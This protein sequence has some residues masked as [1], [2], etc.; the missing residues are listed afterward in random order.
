ML[1]GM[2]LR[3]H[4]AD[5]T[6]TGSC[7]LV[8][9]NGLRLMLD[10]GMFQGARE[11]SR[12]ANSILPDDL[13]NVDAVILSHGHLDHCGRLPL[14]CRAGFRGVIYATPATIDVARIVMLD[15]A[16]IQEE[17]SL[18]LNRR[19]AF[20][21]REP[22]KPLFTTADVQCVLP[23]FRPVRY[24]ETVDLGKNVRFTFR[25]AGHILGSA[26]V[27]LDADENGS[28]RRLLFTGDIGRYGTPIIRDPDPL[29]T[30]GMNS[31][32]P[33]NY[34]AVITE[35]T[36]G[37][38]K[39]A[40]MEEVPPQL[41]KIL[42]ETIARKGRLILPS[43]AVGRTQ[44]MLYYVQRFIQAKEIP[45]IPIFV[46]SPMG[47]EVSRITQ[48]H[49][50]FFDSDTRQAIGNKDLFGTSHVTFTVTSEESRRINN[51]SGPAVIIASSPTCEFGRILHHLKRSVENADDTIVFVGYT[52][53]NTLGRRLQDGA[54][55]VRILDRIFALRCKVRTLHGLSAHADG[56]ELL[57]FLR[58]AI[59]R[60]G[61]AFV[62][63][64]EEA[65][66][67]G[68]AGRLAEAGFGA[69]LAPAARTSAVVGGV[70][71]E[72]HPVATDE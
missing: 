24:N 54:R 44:S 11:E 38:I 43:F 18:Y 35:S 52:P 3:F 58:P 47:A 5:R 25:D 39:H 72:T 71:V 4:G 67:D 48:D 8:E 34:D 19:S 68:F 56:D 33:G 28:S 23:R 26:Y 15:A 59:S 37:T 65:R 22:V 66:C 40:P 29:P 62:V 55:Q 13:K 57:R 61:T 69:A 42:K 36:Y 46:D 64:G 6:V 32:S 9:V 50:D 1:S 49:A 45:E 63:H 14:L 70:A 53:A 7:H 31:A 27:I 12:V 16:K 21:Q 10:F 20:A 51:V 17:D 30:V 60:G 41:L 2:L